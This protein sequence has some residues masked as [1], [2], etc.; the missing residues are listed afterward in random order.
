M[1]SPFESLP[2]PNDANERNRFIHNQRISTRLSPMDSED[3]FCDDAVTLADTA[4]EDRHGY[5]K[6]FCGT[7][8]TI[9]NGDKCCG[10]T[11]KNC[12]SAILWQGAEKFQ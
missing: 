8:H 6:C 12:G 1:P 7:I 9:H 11:C 2:H 10:P 4:L 5:L 3:S